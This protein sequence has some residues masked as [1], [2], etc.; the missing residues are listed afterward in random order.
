MRN[1][2]KTTPEN[3]VS[4]TY[5]S[6][7]LTAKQLA[8]TYLR[9]YQHNLIDEIIASGDPDRQQQF[10]AWFGE[11]VWNKL[12]ALDAETAA[13]HKKADR[14]GKPPFAQ[15]RL[16]RE[17]DKLGLPSAAAMHQ[18][19]KG[20][21]AKDVHK[22]FEAWLEK[23]KLP[24]MPKPK[25]RGPKRKQ[26]EIAAEKAAKLEQ[27]KRDAERKRELDR[28]HK[29]LKFKRLQRTL[30]RLASAL[31]E[32]RDITT[33]E[34]VLLRDV[35]D[36]EN[37]LDRPEEDWAV[38]WPMPSREAFAQLRALLEDEDIVD[39]LATGRREKAGMRKEP[40]PF[41]RTSKFTRLTSE[42]VAEIAAST[43][44]TEY[45]A[46]KYR[47]PPEK[48][49]KLRGS[50]QGNRKLTA[51]EVREIL[52]YATVQD[53]PKKTRKRVQAHRYGVSYPAICKI[54]KGE[55]WPDVYAEV[56]VQERLKADE[57]GE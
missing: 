49:R 26:A 31:E 5:T 38:G 48:I 21:A 28:I 2:C 19:Y 30:T 37:L 45:L 11:D 13:A 20:R 50:R 32:L 57:K 25:Y 54:H 17:A 8:K 34:D 40:L 41:K 3:G 7:N 1:L 15:A 9:L 29:D 36:V 14:K 16:Q 6:Q 22:M 46:A 33:M 4:R 51:D 42:Q 23:H 56:K 39:F 18:L 12:C 35:R 24:P 43:E 55:T 44:R 10:F 53:I 27:Q 47:V 52:T